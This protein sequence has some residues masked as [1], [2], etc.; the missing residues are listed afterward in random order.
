MKALYRVTDPVAYAQFKKVHAVL[1]QHG[2]DV[3]VVYQSNYYMVIACI[4]I[5]LSRTVRAQL[6]RVN[7]DWDIDNRPGKKSKY[8][9]LKLTFNKE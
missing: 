7:Y 1:K 2:P 3:M 4:D 9:Y 5:E 6:S 8:H